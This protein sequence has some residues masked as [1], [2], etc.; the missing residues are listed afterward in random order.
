MSRNDVATSRLTSGTDSLVSGNGSPSLELV[1]LVQ[2]LLAGTDSPGLFDDP[3]L[4]GGV[5]ARRHGALDRRQDGGTAAAVLLQ[6]TGVLSQGL[7]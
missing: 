7:G 1:D 4:I 6:I 2:Q 3:R 5:N